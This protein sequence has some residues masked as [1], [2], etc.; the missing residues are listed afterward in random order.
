VNDAFVIAGGTTQARSRPFQIHQV[1]RNNRS[2]QKNRKGFRRAIRRQRY[3]YQPYSLI[4]YNSRI[5]RVKGTHNKGKRVMVAASPKNKSLSV[6]KIEL[7]KYGKGFQFLTA[8][9]PPAKAR[10]FPLGI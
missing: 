5:Y 9:P 3:P 10:G 1:R 4:T 2:L 7:V 8:I 6:T